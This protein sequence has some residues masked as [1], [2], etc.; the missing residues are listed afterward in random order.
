ML[1]KSEVEGVKERQK[2]KKGE[3]F[4]LILCRRLKTDT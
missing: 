2:G 1:V 4:H 3:L